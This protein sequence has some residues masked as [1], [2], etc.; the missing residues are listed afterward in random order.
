MKIDW[1][2]IQLYYDNNHTWRQISKKFG[3]SEGAISNAKKKGLFISRSISEASKLSNKL[4]PKKLSEETKNKI[5]I[6]RKKYLMENPDKVPYLLNHSSKGPSYPEKYFDEVFNC[7][8]EY[9]KYLQVGIYHIDF[10]VIDKMIAIE[11]DGEQ[12]YLDRKIV[13][14]DK[15]K[16]K[17]LIENGWDIIRIRWSDYQKMN[18]TEKEI[19]IIELIKY[20]RSLIEIKPKIKY[21]KNEN[22]CACGKKIHKKSKMCVKCAPKKRKVKNR[23]DKD[24]ILKMVNESSLE[25]VGRKYGVTGNA[26]KKWLK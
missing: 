1:E 6:T 17:Y 13:E 8:F 21:K 20:I 10:A 2:E 7:E 11:V 25:A 4:Y 12:H 19:Y 24:E 5:S 9:E 22:F 14:S 3:I 16:N 26:V 18:R 15:R 23:P